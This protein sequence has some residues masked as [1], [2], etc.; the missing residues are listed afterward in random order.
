MVPPLVFFVFPA[1]FVVLL[2]PAVVIV[3]HQM[4]PQL[5]K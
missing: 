4:L 2:G 3:L 1:L 5:S